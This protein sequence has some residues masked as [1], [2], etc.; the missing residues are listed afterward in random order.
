MKRYST[1]GQAIPHP[2]TPHV[3]LHRLPN[4]TAPEPINPRTPLRLRLYSRVFTS[5]ARCCPGPRRRPP[6]WM[7]SARSGQRGQRTTSIGS[8]LCVERLTAGSMVARKEM[9]PYYVQSNDAST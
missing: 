8:R 9:P 3:L 1:V 5:P 2:S 7:R 4:H 6:P